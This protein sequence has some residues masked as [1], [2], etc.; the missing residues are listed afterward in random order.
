MFDIEVKVAQSR[1]IDLYYQVSGYVS[2]WGTVHVSSVSF[3]RTFKRND[4]ANF[5]TEHEFLTADE[6]KTF[7]FDR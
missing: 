4:E 2:E 7:K 1:I 5:H 3:E 6:L